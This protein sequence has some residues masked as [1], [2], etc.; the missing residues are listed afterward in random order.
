MIAETLDITEARRQ[1]GSLPERLKEARIIWVT[2]HHK[3]AFALVD[4]YVMEALM[5]T[6]DIF[7]DPGA[8]RML[9]ESVEDIQAGRLIDHEKLRDELA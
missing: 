2:R 5:E 7:D 8:L 4:M 6:L 3:R 1:F 9:A